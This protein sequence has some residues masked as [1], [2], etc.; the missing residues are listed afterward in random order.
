MKDNY[1]VSL[2]SNMSFL[3]LR[4]SVLTTGTHSHGNRNDKTPVKVVIALNQ[5]PGGRYFDLILNFN[6]VPNEPN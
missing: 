3:L 2:P 1:F 4:W 5:W 6:R